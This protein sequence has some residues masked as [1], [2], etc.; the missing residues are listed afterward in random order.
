MSKAAAES[1]GARRLQRLQ[2]LFQRVCAGVTERVAA[3]AVHRR[4]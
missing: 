1:G 4:P 2:Q 3:V